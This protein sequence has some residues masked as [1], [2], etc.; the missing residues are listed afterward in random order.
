MWTYTSYIL[1]KVCEKD[2][3]KCEEFKFTDLS[4]FIFNILYRKHRV[5]F[6]DGEKDL[7]ND[8]YYLKELDILD[9]NDDNDDDYEKIILKIK[10]IDKLN[11][12]ASIVKASPR[13]TK[14]ELF[15]DYIE[16]I[17]KAVENF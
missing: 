1:S 13:V 9:F 17:D 11:G 10:N 3:S 6:H 16:K 2:A 15:K 14:I 5:I 8:L 4:E 12:I 7:Y